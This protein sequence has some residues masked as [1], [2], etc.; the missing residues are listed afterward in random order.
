MKKSI[1]LVLVSTFVLLG[2]ALP[3]K[4]QTI[5]LGANTSDVVTGT[6]VTFTPSN[7]PSLGSAQLSR[8]SYSVISSSGRPIEMQV[9]YRTR[10]TDECQGTTLTTS[11]N[12]K[13]CQLS[14]KTANLIL[15]A[16]AVAGELGASTLR[17]K[18]MEDTSAQLQVRAWIDSDLD[19]RIDG[20]EHHSSTVMLRNYSIAQ[21]PLL[22]NFQ[23]EPPVWGERFAASIGAKGSGDSALFGNRIVDLSK[24]SLDSMQSDNYP[25]QEP[26]NEVSVAPDYPATR[27]IP[28]PAYF[29]NLGTDQVVS[30]AFSQLF[31]GLYDTANLPINTSLNGTY[32]TAQLEIFNATKGGYNT[33][34]GAPITNLETDTSGH[35]RFFVNPSIEPLGPGRVFVRYMSAD[36]VQI[37]A[38]YLPL[39]FLSSYSQDDHPRWKRMVFSAGK[40]I[41][42]QG[43]YEVNLYYNPFGNKRVK[44]ATQKFDYSGFQVG[45]VETAVFNGN[46]QLVPNSADAHKDQSANFYSLPSNVNRFRY[47]FVAKDVNGKTHANW[48]V[49]IRLN[50]QDMATKSIRVDNVVHTEDEALIYRITDGAG[51]VDL[52]LLIPGGRVPAAGE[53]IRI[54]PQIFGMR[55]ALLP[56]LDKF[57]SVISWK[58]DSS[59]LISGDWQA[60]G[61]NGSAAAV[62]LKV[63]RPSGAAAQ[64]PVIVTAEA[65]LDVSTSSFQ[66]DSTGSLFIYVKLSAMALGKGESK[67]YANILEGDQIK[68]LVWSVFWESK[69]AKLVAKLQPHSLAKPAVSVNRQLGNQ[70]VQFSLYKQ[71]TSYEYI[72]KM[73]SLQECPVGSSPAK[74]ALEVSGGTLASPAPTELASGEFSL[75]LKDVRLTDLR[76]AGILGSCLTAT[77]SPFEFLRSTSSDQ[78]TQ[79]SLRTGVDVTSSNGKIVVN[80]YQIKGSRLSIKIGGKWYR[81]NVTRDLDSWLQNSTP[82]RVVRVDVYVDGLLT[83]SKNITVANRFT[84]GQVT[85]QKLRNPRQTLL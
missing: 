40:A 53:S 43:V 83:L 4:A 76:V 72:L 75:L 35:V 63:R 30:E 67:V 42:H 15:V 27:N 65:P 41:S 31:L 77:S 85:E 52:D 37:A 11:G 79:N 17:L 68:Q 21:L 50:Q 10:N 49:Y 7:F 59:L 23:I 56:R 13:F 22:L 20:Y 1:V 71:A 70:S 46:N 25:F 58:I 2:Q 38:N 28:Q 84:S 6:E 8:Y 32:V 12:Y 33:V 61:S 48:P 45:E 47:S 69:E 80:A 64:V 24:F 82:G 62:N 54:E 74:V 18:V 55:E 16:G 9:N 36:N 66:S 3:A 29:Q 57:A 81:Y 39:T 19:M 78:E 73:K 14:T 44:I 51:R 60:S 34:L 5:G 26:I